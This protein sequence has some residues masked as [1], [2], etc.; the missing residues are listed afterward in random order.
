[1]DSSAIDQQCSD[2]DHSPSLPVDGYD[3]RDIVNITHPKLCCISKES[4]LNFSLK[5]IICTNRRAV[6]F[7][8][9]D[10]FHFS[11]NSVSQLLLAEHY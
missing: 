2:P 9:G 8:V 1:M 7:I 5:V 10:C 11:E 4:I 6:L 3:Q